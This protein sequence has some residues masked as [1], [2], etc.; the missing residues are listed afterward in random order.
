MARVTA[1]CY[2]ILYKRDTLKADSV[3]HALASTALSKR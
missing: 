3:Q 1:A 2:M